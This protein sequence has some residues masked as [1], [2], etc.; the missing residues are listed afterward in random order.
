M[1]PTVAINL[2]N[3]FL[4]QKENCFNS[5]VTEKQASLGPQRTLPFW[6]SAN[7][8]AEKQERPQF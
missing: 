5:Y 7:E 1:K 3:K 6:L 4:Q 8:K 2:E